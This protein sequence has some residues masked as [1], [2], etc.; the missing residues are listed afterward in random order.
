MNATAW[1]SVI[2]ERFTGEQRAMCVRAFYENNHSFVT[3]PRLCRAHYHLHGINK[4]PS[5][6]LIRFWIEKFERDGT[7]KNKEPTGRPRA[8]RNPENIL[9]LTISYSAIR[10][11]KH[12][13]HIID[14]NYYKLLLIVSSSISKLVMVLVIVVELC[15][16]LDSND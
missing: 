4:T 3:V 10:M 12:N 15:K 13:S 9:F 16:S 7:T 6:K 5:A 2:V 8:A 11:F 1:K 14:K